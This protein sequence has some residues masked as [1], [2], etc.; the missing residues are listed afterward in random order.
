MVC[1]VAWEKITYNGSVLCVRRQKAT[2]T[3]VRCPAVTQNTMLY[4]AIRDLELFCHN[5]KLKK[6]ERSKRIFRTV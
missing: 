1:S 6:N 3:S 2:T 4:A 5:Y